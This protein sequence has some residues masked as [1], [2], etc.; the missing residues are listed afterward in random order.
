LTRPIGPGSRLSVRLA[1][2]TP[3]WVLL[4][5]S[6]ASRTYFDAMFAKPPDMLGIPVAA[7]IDAIAIAWM[8]I[9]LV[10]IWDTRSQLMQSLVLAVFTIPATLLIVLAPAVLV[11]L[12]NFG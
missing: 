8:L 5:V 3:L 9:G 7:V 10:L 4:I 1:A 6:V 11:I 2:L 12:Q